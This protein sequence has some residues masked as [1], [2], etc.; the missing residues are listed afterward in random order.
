MSL[1]KASLL[2]CWFEVLVLL[3]AVT[4]VTSVI[5]CERSNTKTSAKKPAAWSGGRC[6]RPKGDD[7]WKHCKWQVAGRNNENWQVAATF[8]GHTDSVCSVSWS[9]DQSRI[10]TASSDGTAI[11]WEEGNSSNRFSQGFGWYAAALL[12]YPKDD[13]VRDAVWSPDS[14]KVLTGNIDG[15]ARVWKL[16]E[17]TTK[18][19]RR[20][21]EN[22]SSQAGPPLEDW[23]AIAILKQ[24]DTVL[25]VD[26]PSNT[27]SAGRVLT[28]KRDRT[29]CIRRS[30]KAGTTSKA[31]LAAT[32]KKEGPPYA[33]ITSCA[34]Q[35]QR[36]R[37]AYGDT[38]MVDSYDHSGTLWELNRELPLNWGLS[39]TLE[40]TSH[41]VTSIRWSP[42]SEYLLT[43]G[44]DGVVRIWSFVSERD[45]H[46]SGRRY[47][48][49]L[50]SHRCHTEAVWLLDWA[51]DSQRVITGG[52]NSS[53]YIWRPF[54]PQGWVLEAIL[55]PTNGRSIKAKRYNSASHDEFYY[56]RLDSLKPDYNMDWIAPWSPP[57]VAAWSPDGRRVSEQGVMA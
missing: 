48:D 49:I 39:A 54:T 50:S 57:W 36:D 55:G 47:W 24:H 6:V 35:D 26:W 53:G 22:V 3:T 29:A 27:S 56:D 25:A 1:W 37:R 31:T 10:V 42:T 8:E 16:R 40:A 38:F 43:G 46:H 12:G 2:L 52:R 41:L 14:K 21:N 5:F 19:A 13:P 44:N 28:G 32:I 18:E 51:P 30:A 15:V 7:G 23:E 45:F 17:N 34:S 33:S 9:P 4:S 20:S 11:L